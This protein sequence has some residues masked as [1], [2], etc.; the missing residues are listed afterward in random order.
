MA[1]I[2]TSSSK[3]VRVRSSDE[4]EGEVTIF[5]EGI[6]SFKSSEA[7]AVTVVSS[8]SAVAAFAAVAP[9]SD[10]EGVAD[11]TAEV[12]M[13]ESKSQIFLWMRLQVK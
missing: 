9:A 13:V 7:A 11:S 4:G 2:K 10:V 6:S 5:S 3:A 12:D 1:K 8:V